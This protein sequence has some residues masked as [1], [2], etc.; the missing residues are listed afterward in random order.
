MAYPNP[1]LKIG[2][3]KKV[4]FPLEKLLTN[5]LTINSHARE[6]VVS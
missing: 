1:I 5:I 4:S 2:F 6:I 3:V